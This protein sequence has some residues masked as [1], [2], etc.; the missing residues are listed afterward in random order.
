M[1][2]E[3]A[4][5]LRLLDLAATDT[6]IAQLGHRRRTL[7]IHA[8]IAELAETRKRVK[9]RLVQANTQ[10]SDAK[11]QVEKTER[12]I[13]PMRVRIERDQHRL[14]T[15]A[16]TD[17]K[18]VAS[19]AAE[20]TKMRQRLDD[21]ED[22]SLDAMQALEDATERQRAIQV[23]GEVAD[24]RLRELLKQRDAAVAKLD[25]QIRDRERERELLAGG[26]PEE[27]LSIYL[28]SHQRTGLGAARLHQGRCSGCGLE[29]NPAELRRIKAALSNEVL[30][31]EECGRILV[32]TSESGL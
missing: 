25:E 19:L 6:E 4:L 14:D 13:E 12:D 17:P 2:A 24:S 9:A 27:L 1:L 26:L 5:Q 20:L 7:P 16:V 18:V 10:V 3:P 15:G 11:Y 23:E 21:L 28:R 30:R 32:R 31:C 29:L 8:E 22:C